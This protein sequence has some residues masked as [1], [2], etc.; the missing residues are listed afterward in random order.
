[1]L[2][3]VPPERLTVV[4]VSVFVSLVLANGSE[5]PEIVYT[6][7]LEVLIV[8]PDGSQSLHDIK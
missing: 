8:S 7:Q 5:S 6:L 2:P 3:D 4:T 1:M